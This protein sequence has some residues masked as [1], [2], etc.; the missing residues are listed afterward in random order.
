MWGGVSH[1]VG[2][3]QVVGVSRGGAM[4]GELLVGV[5]PKRTKRT[6]GEEKGKIG[7]GS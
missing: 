7:Q 2:F 1:V 3:P 4:D 5:S 6:A